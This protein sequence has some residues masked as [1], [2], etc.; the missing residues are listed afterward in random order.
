MLQS[1]IIKRLFN[2]FDYQIDLKND[3]IT[4]LTGP[5]GYGKTTI[6]N[7]IYSIITK[8]IAY[9]IDL[10]FISITLFF[11]RN[12][13]EFNKGK[14]TNK[15]FTIDGNNKNIDYEFLVKSFN[16][17]VL[18]DNELRYML[19][20]LTRIPKEN[21]FEINNNNKKKIVTQLI[22]EYPELINKEIPYQLPENISTYLIKEQ[23]LLKTKTSFRNIDFYDNENREKYNTLYQNAI[24]ENAKSLAK[25]LTEKLKE[26]DNIARENDSSYINRLLKGETSINKKEFDERYIRIN[27]TKKALSKFGLAT[28]EDEESTAFNQADA[29]ALSL[30]L[31]DAEKK[32]SVFKDFLRK[33]EIFVNILNKRDFTNKTIIVAPEF[34]YKF[35]DTNTNEIDLGNL[36]SGEQHE[37]IMIYELIFN[38]NS[39]TIVLIDEPEISLH[40]NWQ[41]NFIDDLKAILKLNN[42]NVVVATHSPQIINGN[43]D[44]T[45]DLFEISS[46]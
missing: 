39:D 20:R 46:N 29:K 21:N 5:N 11:D 27:K 4:I 15:F 28:I 22:E 9:L 14:T 6:L 10:P 12:R 18:I 34:G 19:R 24:I 43:W 32:I 26:S 45:T 37:L 41:K 16:E 13:I 23:R 31:D 17:E 7:I 25:L 3:G 2:Q 44:L 35:I 38:V 8:N 30:F 36:S 42:F 1:I 40:V 33:L